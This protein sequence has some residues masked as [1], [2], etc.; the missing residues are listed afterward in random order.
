MKLL[1]ISKDRKVFDEGSDV[2]LRTLEYSKLFD[3]LH[4]VVLAKTPNDKL[5]EKIGHNLVLYSPH[6]NNFFFVFLKAWGVVFRLGG[7]L[8]KEKDAW[9]TAQDPF[10]S[11]FLAFLVSKMFSLKLQL[12]IHT[13]FLSP[14]FKKGSFLN[15]FRV[16]LSK[17]ILSSAD[18]IRV[19]SVRIK[20]SLSSLKALS[21]KPQTIHTLPVFV[22]ADK[23]K[24]QKISFDLRKKY[25][26]FGKIILIAS[27]LTKEKNI[28]LG[29]D[30]FKKILA[31]Q[32][33]VGLI[34]AGEGP[35]RGA[36]EKYAEK[37]GVVKQ[38]R[39]LG[40]Q[41]DIISF[42]KSADLFLS[43]SF[44][45]GYGMSILE[46]LLSGCPVLSTDVGIAREAG[47]LIIA[48][49]NA[50]D[51][52]DKAIEILNSPRKNIEINVLS[53]QE[54]LEKFKETFDNQ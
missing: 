13:D 24:N 7:K 21:S 5:Q 51:F 3:E 31:K 18:S 43:T 39:F 46:A 36:L 30:V 41:K 45:E 35:L 25:P 11:G 12:Q 53:K 6:S 52:A 23:I 37:I 15:R 22:D 20:D 8:R 42:Y 19:V 9:V 54:Y 47:A 4:V 38:V 26:E 10:E 2:R 49:L 14:Y 27:R 48:S 40:W 34:V 1:M 50:A 16:F 44:Y 28:F 17:R 33:N 29:L 32:N